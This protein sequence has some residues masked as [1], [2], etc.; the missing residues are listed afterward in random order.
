MKKTEAGLTGTRESSPTE[1]KGSGLLHA[2]QVNRK[3]LN[4]SVRVAQ[5]LPACPGLCAGFLRRPVGAWH[6][7]IGKTI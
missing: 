6:G 5:F 3:L 4:T 1:H 2:K 7:E